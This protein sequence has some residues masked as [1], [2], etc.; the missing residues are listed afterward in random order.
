LDHIRLDAIREY[1]KDTRGIQRR[2]E[3]VR[4]ILGELYLLMLENNPDFREIVKRRMDEDGVTVDNIRLWKERDEV[5][6]EEV[7]RP[8]SGA[9]GD[10][11]AVGPDLPTKAPKT[12]TITIMPGWTK[13]F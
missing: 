2:S 5:P 7:Q 11:G 1:W 10:S 3:V 6:T 12:P 8:D 4:D 9:E 13:P